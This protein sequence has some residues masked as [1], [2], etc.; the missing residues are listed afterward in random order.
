MK[1][2]KV[3]K[4][5]T[6]IIPFKNHKEYHITLNELDTDKT[7]LNNFFS[8]LEK[9]NIKIIKI[10]YLGDIYSL[11]ANRYLINKYPS[12]ILGNSE[13]IRNKNKN[14]SIYINAI[15][16]KLKQFK[17]I[18]NNGKNIGAY[19]SFPDIKYASIAGLVVSNNH[20]KNAFYLDTKKIYN[21][22][23]AVLSKFGFLPTDIFRFWNLIADISKNYLSFN[24]ARDEYFKKHRIICYPAATGIEAGL[25]DK[26]RINL[27]FEAI[28]IKNKKSRGFIKIKSKRQCE[29]FFYGPKF[30]RAVLLVFSKDKVRKLFISGTS[31]VNKEGK[32][33]LISEPKKNINYVMNCFEH[34]L[35]KNKMTFRNIVMAH[36][37]FKNQEI[38]RQFKR[39]YFERKLNFPYNPVFSNICRKD[40]LFEIEG[41]AFSKNS[42]KDDR[43]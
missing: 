34:L 6:A 16:G 38:Y 2:K 39:F 42:K 29:S 14:S 36:V 1:N 41:I 31:S 24:I 40:F 12:I 37:Y 10:V 8:I 13:K 28:R 21:K 15:S 32:S 7:F 26:K 35:K 23:D 3:S 19:Y 4:I 43:I 27:S 9:N 33:I 20:G 25:P 11:K 17:Y 22:I 30:S 5:K 18:K